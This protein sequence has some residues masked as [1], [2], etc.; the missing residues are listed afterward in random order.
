MD[1]SI[2]DRMQQVTRR[3]RAFVDEELIPLERDYLTQG[4]RVVLDA[5]REKRAKVKQEGLWLPQIHKEY[6]GMGLSTL[7]H[8]LVSAELGRSPLGHYTFNCQA[9]DAGNME[10]LIKYGT[11]EQKERF[12]TPLLAGDIRSCFSMTEPDYPGSNPVWMGTTAVRDGNEWVINGTKWFSTGADGASFAIVMAITNPDAPKHLRASQILVPIDTPGV[13]IEENTPSMGWRGED[14]ASHS[15][16][17]YENVRVPVD[18]ILGPDGA[19]FLIAQDR[20]GPGRIHHC[21]RWMGVCERSFE[22]MCRYALQRR[23]TPDHTLADQQIVRAWIAES[24]AEINAARL[25]VL[26]AAWCIDQCG[27]KEARVE[28]S[29]IKFHAANTMMRVIDRA[30][31]VHGGLGTTDYT[32]LALFFRNERAG[33]IYDGPDEVHKLSAAKRILAQFTEADV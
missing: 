28:I 9:P 14:W 17:R 31:Q 33:R 3:V 16:I 7:E 13:C 20:L 22:L 4:F 2:S 10:I 11:D 23:V 32:P 1:F 21:M 19:G 15:R 30:I 29:L 5:L 27:P 6:G 25:A 26:H 8:G 18:N 24:R 12:L